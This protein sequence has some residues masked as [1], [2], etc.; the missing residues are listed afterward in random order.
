MVRRAALLGVGFWILSAG[1]CPAADL[2][3]EQVRAA[4]REA[5]PRLEAFWKAPASY[6]FKADTRRLDIP[7]NDAKFIA[8]S[9]QSEIRVRGAE[10]RWRVDHI[11]PA[12]GGTV[13][14]V[15]V[16][17]KDRRFYAIKRVG[18]RRPNVVE[19]G[20]TDPIYTSGEKIVFAT[21]RASTVLYNRIDAADILLSDAYDLTVPAGSKPGE[22][23]VEFARKPMPEDVNKRQYVYTSG[24]ITF[25]PGRD[26]AISGYTIV[27]NTG[28]T[29]VGTHEYQE[30]PALKS[31][32]MPKRIQMTTTTAKSTL[33]TI[34]T[35]DVESIEPG[36]VDDAVFDPEALGKD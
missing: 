31:R 11:R 35:L 2:S 9:A 1:R 3:P 12:A 20:E 13:E 6:V 14:T 36:P 19:R 7:P 24:T 26:W 21:C 29:V 5:R 10:G 23:T 33:K 28:L 30:I 16:V 4:Y 8:A 34:E 22:V 32:T 27:T 18:D 25:L 15:I 17:T